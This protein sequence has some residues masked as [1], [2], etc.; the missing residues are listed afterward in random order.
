MGVAVGVNKRI[1]AY[2]IGRL[3]DRSPDV[4]LKAIQ[5][6]RLLADPE[7]LGALQEVYRSDSS[8][9]VRRA[10][11]EAGRSIFATDQARKGQ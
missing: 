1:V 9:E 5:E 4:R 6:L 11:Q 7:A 8:A 3:Q 10:A 2:H